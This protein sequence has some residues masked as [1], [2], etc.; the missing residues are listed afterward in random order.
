MAIPSAHIQPQTVHP[1]NKFNKSTEEKV[2]FPLASI[3]GIIYITASNIIIGIIKGES[4]TQIY[5]LF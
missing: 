2:F 3:A 1:K 4:I 5:K